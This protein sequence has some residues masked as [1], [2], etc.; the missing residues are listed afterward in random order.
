V[1]TAEDGLA[2][3][4]RTGV[5]LTRTT[6]DLPRLVDSRLADDKEPEKV[7]KGERVDKPAPLRRG[8]E[9]DPPAPLRSRTGLDDS[10]LLVGRIPRAAKVPAPIRTVLSARDATAIRTPVATSNVDGKDARDASGETVS[11]PGE[12]PR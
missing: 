7:D 8:I 5:D 10:A 1:I 9:S 6:P 12:E 4:N 3:R 11:D 2:A